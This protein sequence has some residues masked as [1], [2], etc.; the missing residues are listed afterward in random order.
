MTPSVI[1]EKRTKAIAKT[2]N[3]FQ[4]RLLRGE[5]C[6]RRPWRRLEES[7]ANRASPQG[8]DP[9]IGIAKAEHFKV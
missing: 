8:V 1:D 6:E 2:V 7:I 5:Q 4:V 3:P 9:V